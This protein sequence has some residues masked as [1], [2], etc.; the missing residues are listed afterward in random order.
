MLSKGWSCAVLCLAC[1][2][3]DLA[4]NPARDVAGEAADTTLAGVGEAADPAP[5]ADEEAGGQDGP[6]GGDW[7][8]GPLA[9]GEAA[10]AV[11]T[12]RAV[13]VAT[14]AGYDRVVFDF[15]SDPVPP[16][17]IGTLDG[18]AIQCGSGEAVDLEGETVLEF[19]FEPARAHTEAG[20]A[21]VRERSLEPAL[22]VVRS[23]VLTCDFEAHVVWAAGLAG[24]VVLRTMLL[25][26]PHR[27][28]L[29]LA[30]SPPK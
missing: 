21:T 25:A 17:R 1:G 8:T 7:Q 30:R 13:R 12:L 20:A 2:G 3:A 23:L 4:E 28:V 10:A 9:G 18:R 24:S 27:L 6:A 15:G 11:A 14:H 26:D 5:P 16:Y 29:D 19:S 22:P